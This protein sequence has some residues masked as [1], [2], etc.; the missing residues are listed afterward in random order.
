MIYNKENSTFTF[1]K[2]ELEA[3]NQI[4]KD[5]AYRKAAAC[6]V[7]NLAYLQEL[8]IMEAIEILGKYALYLIVTYQ[9]DKCHCDTEE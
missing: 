6:T 5:K 2:K 9:L 4:I 7:E 8:P 1:T 3:H